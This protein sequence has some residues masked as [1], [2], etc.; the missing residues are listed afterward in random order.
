MTR[1]QARETRRRRSRRVRAVLAGGLVFGV[2]AAATLASWTDQEVAT[3]TITAGTFAIESRTNLGSFTDSPNSPVLTLP[4]GAM[5]LYPGEKRAAWIQVQNKG[6]VPGIVS[7][8]A[9]NV[10]G[11]DGVSAPVGNSAKLQGALKV[12]VAVSTTTNAGVAPTCTTSTVTTSTATGVN[13][14]PAPVATGSL[15][16]NRGNIVTFC[17][18]VELPTAAANDTQGGDVRPTW[19]FTATTPTT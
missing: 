17:I 6:S 14:V 16:A 2:G 10:V 5:G 18:V 15:S 4:L 11:S 9:V 8:S 12:G 19:T 7:L 1:R 13:V 3:A